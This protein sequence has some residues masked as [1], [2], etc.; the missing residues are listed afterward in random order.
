MFHFKT[1]RL[2]AWSGIVCVLFFFGAFL[3]SGFIPVPG[4]SMTQEEVVAMYQQH[5]SGIRFG[6][7]LMLLSSGLYLPL[8]AAISIQMK[9]IEG[10]ETPILTY[11]QLAAGTFS[12][13]TYFLPSLLF[14]VT[15]FRPDRPPE[16]TYLMNDLSFI[17]LIIPLSPFII[18][19]VTF[20]LVVLKDDHPQPIFPRWL[21]F[22]NFW[23]ALSFLTALFLPFFKTGPFAWN[24]L[25]VF[26]LPATLFALWFFI[27]AIMLLKAI[28][29]QEREVSA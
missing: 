7:G 29:R 11:I 12:A 19:Y 6:M 22:Y 15:A 17:V 16:L 18:Q 25:L 20:G 5:T 3:L 21:A 4:P 1:Q 26:W 27:M 24:G 10:N 28:D 13:I 9:R 8:V 23:S 2:C 14:I